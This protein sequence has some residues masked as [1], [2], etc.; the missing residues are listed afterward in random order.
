MRTPVILLLGLGGVFFAV[1]LLLPL[2]ACHTE[3]LYTR[4]YVHFYEERRLAAVKGDI[5]QAAENLKSVAEYKSLKVPAEGD[6]GRALK[7]VRQAAIREI[8]ARMRTLSGDDLGEDPEPWIKKYQHPSTL[9]SNPGMQA[10][11]AE[12]PRTEPLTREVLLHEHGQDRHWVMKVGG[13]IKEEH[14]LTA[15][16]DLHFVAEYAHG[17]HTPQVDSMG[18]KENAEAIV[19]GFWRNGRPMSTT[20]QVGEKVNGQDFAWWPNGNIAREASFVMGMPSSTWMF[21]DQAGKL[22][23]EGTYKDGKRWNGVFTGSERPGGDFFF[24]MYPMKKKAYQ[25]G[26][27]VREEDFLDE[28][29]AE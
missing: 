1:L 5:Q 25:D 29:R 23:G 18:E 20:P 27:L 14:S 9:R 17:V 7:V 6:L 10:G 26:N 24:T 2:M 8:I 11:V 28:L 4:I 13:L 3:K 15:H 19:K 16:G 22:V 21:Y 12:Q